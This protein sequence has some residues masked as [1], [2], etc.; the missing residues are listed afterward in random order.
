M[1]V[2]PVGTQQVEGTVAVSNLPETQK[3]TG[4]VRLAD[5]VPDL[6]SGNGYAMRGLG[7]DVLLPDDI[8]LTDL[9]VTLVS[10][11]TGICE[12]PLFEDPGA[13]DLQSVVGFV[14]TTDNTTE[15]LH[16]ESGLMPRPGW[17]VAVN[18]NCV[19]Q[20]F[21][22]GTTLPLPRTSEGGE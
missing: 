6:R 9:V 8:L 14:L 10:S 20:V 4:T 2:Q 11:E 7:G 18:G 15:Q 16:L 5:F 21:W 1:P 22:S 3:I 19:I 17:G 12:V 13:G